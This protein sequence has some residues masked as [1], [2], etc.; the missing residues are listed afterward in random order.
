MSGIGPLKIMVVAARTARYDGSM[1]D[2]L[3]RFQQAETLHFLTFSCF[4][5]LPYLESAS[6]KDTVLTAMEHL[7]ARHEARIYAYV[8]M[9]EHVH[10]LI[11]EPPA[12]L[13]GQWVKVF[14]QTVSRGLKGPQER[15]WLAR[16]FD[17]NIRAD[18]EWTR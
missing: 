12:I 14:K 13:L 8:L 5:R 17:A 3:R 4:H 2:G 18:E 15:F 9:P 11:N 7:R 6:A 1:P 16:Y 10:L